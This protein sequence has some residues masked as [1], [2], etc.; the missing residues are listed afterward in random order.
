I[1]I[2]SATRSRSCR[3]WETPAVS[4]PRLLV[5]GWIVGLIVACLFL[6]PVTVRGADLDACRDSLQTG[7]YDE[8]IAQAAEAIAGYAW[9]EDW[10]VLKARAELTIGRYADA[11]A[12]TDAGVKRYPSSVRLRLCAREAALFTG[13][14]ERAAKLLE[15]IDRLATDA[16]WRY[17]DVEDLIALGEASLLYG[18]DARDVLD[19]F[20]DRAQQRDPDRREPYLAC[21]R[22]ALAKQDHELAAD[23]FREASKRFPEDADACFG[24]ARALADSDGNAAADALDACLTHNPRHVPALLWKVER[25]IDAEDYEEAEQ[26]IE[27]VLAIHPHQPEAWGYRAV[28]AHLD[29]DPRG[30][31]LAR[32]KAL[33]HWKTNPLVD[34]TIGRKLS[35]NYRFAEGAAYQQS[36]LAFD[37]KCQPARVQLSQDLLRLGREVEGWAAADAAFQHDGYNVATFNLLELRDVIDRFRTLESEH[38]IVRMEAVEAAAYG[39]DVLELLESARRTLCAKYGLELREKITV[40]IFPDP[41]DFAV[42]TFGM[43]AVSGYLGVCFGKVIT[44]NSPASQGEHPSNWQSVLWHEFCHVVTLELTHNRMPRWLSEGISVYEELQENPAWGQRMTPR[45]REMILGGELTPVGELSSAFL[46]PKSGLHLQFAYFESAL[47]VEFLVERYSIEALQ[48]I[49]RD[50]GAGLPINTALERHTDSLAKLEKEFESFARDRAQQLAPEADWSQPPLE[51]LLADDGDALARWIDE[52]PVNFAALTVHAQTLIEA[53]QWDEAKPVLRTLLAL[54]PE[55]IGGD[56]AYESLAGVHRE[57]GETGE[58]RRLLERYTQLDAAALGA[59]LRLLELDLAA[60]DWP[61]VLRT[62][63]HLSAINPLLPQ[64]H[65]ARSQA[66]ERLAREA[67][68]IASYEALLA[69]GPSDPAEVHYRLARLLHRRHNPLEAKRHVLA[70]L[71]EAPRYRAA[72]Q[73]LLEIVRQQK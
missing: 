72:H 22:L 68:A 27:G 35:Q 73:L 37:A 57:L 23:Y 36:A 49:L 66:A 2:L 16:P 26:L 53:R 38:F 3:E 15:E 34:H 69:L 14:P 48:R 65:R 1:I 43:P 44:A 10:R 59:G 40:E 30:E 67:E 4:R 41:N 56:N 63:E 12:T 61:A 33:A 62:T 71:E 6:A 31:A 25:A 17:S 70:A 19:G 5:V 7:R 11:L 46:P 18:A 55:Y 45:Y 52:H 29:G 8:C 28:L 24:L 54:D 21:G 42:R 58:E 13:D 64:L 60:E 51:S 32:E 9:G 47:V 50:L 20:F 39:K